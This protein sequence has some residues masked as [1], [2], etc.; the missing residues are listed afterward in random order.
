MLALPQSFTLVGDTHS[1]TV[2]GLLVVVRGV[3]DEEPFA[4]LFVEPHIFDIRFAGDLRAM[5]II[6]LVR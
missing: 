1:S 4:D 2:E 5:S 3:H 6:L